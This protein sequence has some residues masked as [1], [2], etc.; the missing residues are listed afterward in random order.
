M[1]LVVAVDKQY[2]TNT[3]Q[4]LTKRLMKKR[5]EL[6]DSRLEYL[7]KKYSLYPYNE[8][9]LKRKGYVLTIEEKDALVRIRLYKKL[10]EE[11]INFDQ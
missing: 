2:M 5:G 7:L 4:K 6:V 8:Q 10:D 11:Y 3:I 1:V 9:E